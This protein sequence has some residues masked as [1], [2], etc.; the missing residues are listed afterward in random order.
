MR[1]ILLSYS[2]ACKRNMRR[3]GFDVGDWESVA[4]DRSVWRQLVNKSKNAVEMRRR[5][6][7]EDRKARR[8][9]EISRGRKP[10]T[11][12]LPACMSGCNRHG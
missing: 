3:G 9:G 1:R 6:E 4:T 10:S 5:L 11:T 7:N 2:D 8:H 12:R